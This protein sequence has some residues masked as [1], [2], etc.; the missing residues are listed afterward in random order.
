MQYVFPH[1]QEVSGSKKELILGMFKVKIF[2]NF[3]I[4]FF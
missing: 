2:Q 3:L 4:L 1:Y